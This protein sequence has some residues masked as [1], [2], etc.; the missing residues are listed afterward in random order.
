M[1]CNKC[2]KP[3]E[4]GAAFCNSCG[5]SVEQ[6]VVNS[7]PVQQQAVN[8]VPIAGTPATGGGFDKKNII[9]IVLAI[10]LVVGIGVGFF[11]GKSTKDD[12]NNDKNVEKRN[13]DNTDEEK[14]KDDKDEKDDNNG[15]KIHQT[16]DPSKIKTKA[17][18]ALGEDIELIKLSYNEERSNLYL[19]LKNNSKKDLSI[20]AYLNYYDEDGT[21]IDRGI[22]TGYIESGKMYLVSIFNSTYEGF[23][24]YDVSINASEYKSYYH[25][26]NV[27]DKI[28]VS[29]VE[30][31]LSLELTNDT[32]N[33]IVSEVTILFYK[34]NE[35]AYY[36]STYLSPKVG[37]TDKHTVSIYS[38]PEYEYKK[39]KVSDYFDRYEI[40]SSYAF[41]YETDY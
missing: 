29:E 8:P 19:L 14:D 40:I 37:L 12:S 23:D 18:N 34:G 35:I 13:S 28:K 22:G 1:N 38:Y 4:P 16:I 7:A 30:S 27:E 15:E 24:S 6:Q 33:D 5:A 10:L 3:L 25:K 17:D 9:I 39:V 41:Y 2:G 11:V 20:T 36:G 21:R 31:G 26:V 32:E